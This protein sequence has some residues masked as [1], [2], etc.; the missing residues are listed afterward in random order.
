MYK[1]NKNVQCLSSYS[2]V[3]FRIELN[4]TISLTIYVFIDEF[5]M[6]ILITLTYFLNRTKLK[7]DYCIRFK[8]TI[9]IKTDL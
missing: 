3:N 7:L 9:S 1:N 4:V 8:I 6:Y 5:Q 2:Y